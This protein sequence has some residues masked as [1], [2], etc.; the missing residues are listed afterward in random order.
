MDRLDKIQLHLLKGYYKEICL[1]EMDLYK[2][3]KLRMDNKCQ[4]YFNSTQIRNA[5]ARWMTYAVYVNRY[6]TITELTRELVTNRQTIVTMIADT[7]AEGWV[8]VIRNKK[9][10]KLK[11]TNELVFRFEEY[12]Q[13]RKAIT[14][15]YTGTLYNKLNDFNNLVNLELK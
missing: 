11:A 4:R 9:G 1:I 2:A 8:E 15:S 5:F 13:W 12:C 6:Y 3:R 10:T 14:K 7:E